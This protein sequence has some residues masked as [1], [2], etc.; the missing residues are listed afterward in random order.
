MKRAR[1]LTLSILLAIL[2]VLIL[3]GVWYYLQATQALPVKRV[4]VAGDFNIIGARRIQTMLLPDVEH[5]MF[6]VN[7]ADIVA[8]LKQFPAI[9]SVKVSRVWPGTVRVTIT[10]YPLLARLPDGDIIATDGHQFR[11]KLKLDLDKIPLFVT[12]NHDFDHVKKTYETFSEILKPADLTI[13]VIEET[14]A[15]EWQLQTNKK[16]WI[17]CGIEHIKPRLTRFVQA[18][19]QLMAQAGKK[20]LAY[21]DLRYHTG[22]AAKWK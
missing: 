21:V 22:F 15:G 20:Q 6:N 11:P 10:P 19:P 2:V 18:Y 12:A 8:K 16:F 3:V 1:K 7:K 13:T 5:G 4:Q 14:E 9:K 17:Y